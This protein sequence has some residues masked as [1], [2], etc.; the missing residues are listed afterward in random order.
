M[1]RVSTSFEFTPGV[2]KGEGGSLIWPIWGRA[3]GMAFGL[4]VLNRVYSSVLVCLKQG[5]DLS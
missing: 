3:V 1:V 5:L 4:S 2:P